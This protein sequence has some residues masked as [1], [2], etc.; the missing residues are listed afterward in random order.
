MCMY[1][2]IYI[3]MCI[4]IYI[5]ICVIYIYIYI[6][7]HDI[8]QGGGAGGPREG[9]PRLVHKRVAPVLYTCSDII[10]CNIL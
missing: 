3:Y 6:Y 5:Y 8:Y 2:Y 7:I 10:Y 4:Y 1:V 9:A